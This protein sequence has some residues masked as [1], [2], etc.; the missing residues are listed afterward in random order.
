MMRWVMCKHSKESKKL[1]SCNVRHRKLQHDGT[2]IRV[3]YYLP[4]E[5]RLPS[6][7]PRAYL[8]FHNPLQ[9]RDR[10]GIKV[11]AEHAS[12]RRKLE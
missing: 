11:Y 3:R 5:E 12:M 1:Q 2:Q 6:R 4:S 10:L 8:P 9:E 7:Q